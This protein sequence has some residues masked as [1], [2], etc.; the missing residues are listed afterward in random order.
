[1]ERFSV[2]RAVRAAV[3]VLAL[4]QSAALG[5]VPAEITVQ[6]RLSSS[7]GVPAPGPKT[8]TFRIFTADIG[9]VQVWPGV[10]GEVQSI[11]TDAAGLWTARVGSIS[12]LSDAVFSGTERWLEITVDDGVNPAEVLSRMKINTSAYA[13]R[14]S[15]VDGATGGHILSKVTIGPNTNTGAEAF[16]AGSS[17]VAYGDYATVTGGEQNS[18]LGSH[19]VICGGLTNNTEGGIGIAIGGGIYNR[20]GP[21]DF[22]VI[23]GGQWN[24]AF[25]E[26]AVVAG[27]GRNDAPGEY[28]VVGG[29]GGPDPS[30]GNV[31][32]GPSSVIGGGLSNYASER[33]AVI[34][35]GNE[36]ISS[37]VAS[38]LA[39]GFQDTADGDFASI[40]GGLYNSTGQ[41]AAVVSG[42]QSNVA[43]AGWS[44]IPGGKGNHAFG[45]FSLAA[46]YRAQA[47]DGSFVWASHDYVSSPDVEFPAAGDPNFAAPLK[48]MFLVCAPGGASIVTG[49]DGSGISTSGV[50]VPAGSG[51][52]SSLSDRTS[53]CDISEI[54]G[55]RLLAK[56]AA[57]PVSQWRYKSQ[58]ESIRH[59]GP[60]AQDFHAAFGVGEDD[61]HI[62]AVDAD[63]V[64][65]AAIKALYELTQRQAAEIEALK[66]EMAEIR[67][68]TR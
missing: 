42:G 55:A 36:N 33:W 38:T 48:Q 10:G 25:A 3:I 21:G 63:G 22:A 58:D 6:G 35:G 54:D 27:G 26:G 50:T 14:L 64:A 47:D 11:S 19:G 43:A 59:I 57:M 13:F 28:S 9:G 8:F 66:S 37:G 29:G 31:A 34:G 18:A 17:N 1:M 30:H 49:I 5:A 23:G 52:W 53:K 60:M 46:G 68:N 4:S 45:A 7:G 51:S 67:V 2:L 32:A 44:A 56:L 65:L 24:D 39:G 16:V 20:T 12:A 62:S 15:T 41:Y 61:R 40:G